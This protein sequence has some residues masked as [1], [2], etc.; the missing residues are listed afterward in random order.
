MV[1][2]QVIEKVDQNKVLKYHTISS[3][4]TGFFF[5]GLVLWLQLL[6]STMVEELQDH[7]TRTHDLLLEI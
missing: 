3:M 7:K 1:N 2:V 5:M 6:L 4:S